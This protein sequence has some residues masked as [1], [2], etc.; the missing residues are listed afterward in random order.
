MRR[1][2][3]AL[4]LSTAAIALL[5]SCGASVPAPIASIA[6]MP[7][8]VNAGTFVQLDASASRDPQSRRLTF[9][10][11]FTARPLGSSAT[12]IDANTATPSFLADLPGE[13]ALNLT[14]SNSV[15]TSTAAATVTVQVSGCAAN[16][17]A[18][19]G[20]QSS[21]TTV[22]IGDSAQFSANVE[23][24]DNLAPCNLDQRLDYAWLLA[25]Q[26]EGSRAS[27]NSERSETPSLTADKAGAYVL[28]LIVT[29]STGRR[30]D[31]GKF[32][33][34]VAECG[35]AT[36]VVA[37]TATPRTTHPN[38]AV[39]LDADVMDADEDCGAEQTFTVQWSVH[40]KPD[41]STPVLSNSR[42]ESPTFTADKAGAYELGVVAT[43]STG[44]S[45]DVGVV[46]VIVD[47]CGDVAPTVASIAA[48]SGAVGTP[49]TGTV[50]TGITVQA[51]G[52][53]SLNCLA[54]GTPA[55]EWSL[56]VPS[57]SRAALSNPAA[58]SPS[59]TPDVAGDYQVSVQVRDSLGIRSAPAVLRI[60]VVDCTP[61]PIQFGTPAISAVATDPD[62][63]APTFSENGNPKPHVGAVVQLTPHAS[64]ASYCGSIAVTPLS[65]RWAITSRPAGSQGALDSPAAASPSLRIDRN[66][67][68][69][70]SVIAT[71]ARGNESAPRSVEIDT[72][73]CGV[74]PISTT[75]LTE[76][77]GP[78]V[79]TPQSPASV[80]SFA[81]FTIAAKIST[82]DNVPTSCPSRFQVGADFSYSVEIQPAANTA[83]LSNVFGDSTVFEASQTGAYAVHVDGA[84]TNL[85]GRVHAPPEFVY[86]S[87]AACS[88]PVLSGATFTVNGAFA[89]AFKGD[90]IDLAVDATPGNCG[91]VS[92][93]LTYSW[94]LSSPPGSA[95]SL[96]A[97]SS[98][99]PSFTADVAGASFAAHVTATDGQGNTSEVATVII[100]V[101]SCGSSP[102]LANILDT[103]GARPFDDHLLQAVPAS[104][105]SFSADEASGCP[106]RFVDYSFAWSVVS[107][108]PSTGFVF[109]ETTSSSVKFTP[110][111]NAVYSIKLV[112]STS[113]Q[114][115][116]VLKQVA[117][118]CSDVVPKTGAVTVASSTPGYPVGSIFRDDIARL[119]ANPTSLCFSPGSTAY[120][121]LWSFTAPTGS[122]SQLNSTTAT[123][124]TFL[125]DL[126]FA[127]YSVTVTVVDK[128][129]NRSPET[130]FSVTSERCGANPILASISDISAGKAFDPHALSVVA[131]GPN[132]K[133]SRDDES[134]LCPARF[135]Q[136]YTFA[137]SIASYG[138]Q[139]QPTDFI[140]N[141]PALATPTEPKTA[142]FTAGTNGSYDVSVL[143][144]GSKFG[145]ATPH[146]VIVVNCIAPNPVVDVPTVTAVSDPENYLKAGLYFRDDTISF[147]GSASSTACYSSGNFHPTFEW[148]LDSDD[149]A[150][151]FTSSTTGAT[152]AAN[153]S[154][155]S[156]DVKLKV[157]DQWNHFSTN[158]FSLVT[159][160]CGKNS[161][162]VLVSAVQ[163][164]G[165][166]LAFDPYTVAI[167][168]SSIDDD[169]AFCPSRFAQTYML[170]STVT[171]PVG[172]THFTP[173]SSSATSFT[174]NIGDN[175]TF[176]VASTATGN[177]SSVVGTGSVDVTVNCPDPTPIFT[178]EPSTAAIAAQITP[179]QADAYYTMHPTD[180][181]KD[182]NVKLTAPVSFACYSTAANAG[183]H[184]NWRLANVD[185]G[186]RGLP[187]LNNAN[188][189]MPDFTAD[190]SSRIYVIGVK[191]LD[192]WDHQATRT[193]RFT[194]GICGAAPIGV[195]VSAAQTPPA[196]P[197]DPWTLTAVPATSS[198]FSNDSDPSMCPVRFAPTYA[199]AWSLNPFSP[200]VQPGTFS[201]PTTNPTTFTPAEPRAY[202]VHLAVTGNGQTGLADATVDATCASPIAGDPGVTEVN[203]A[204]PGP[205]IYVGDV[206]LV[207]AGVA[208]QCFAAPA[209]SSLHYSWT[210]LLEGGTAPE[211]FSPNANVPGP[212]FTPQAFGGNY[213][214]TVAISD[215]SGQVG[216]SNAL[217]IAVS[218]CGAEEP[219]ISLV[220]ARQ[221]FDALN[222]QR[223]SETL[224]SV[225][226]LDTE[227]VPPKTE[228]QATF[229]GMEFPVPF[230][231][232]SSPVQVRVRV[233]SSAGGACP[234]FDFLGA[235][236]TDPDGTEVAT[237]DFTSP[238]AGSIASGGTLEFS[239]TPQVGDR[240]GPP[241]VAGDYH[242]R[243][244]VGYGRPQ[245][246]FQA[247]LGPTLHVAG[248]CGRNAPFPDFTF[249]PSSAAALT[250]VTA[251][252]SL[253]SDEDKDPL[254]LGEGPP[255]F[256]TGC[257]LN[258]PLAYHWDLEAPEDSTT[259]LSPANGV[260]TEFTPDLAGPYDVH[261]TVSDGTTSG[262]NGDG[263]AATTQ[264]YIATPP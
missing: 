156:Y 262:D 124:P 250:L 121:Y 187:T 37:P 159:E 217:A 41:G 184:Y 66:G 173:A 204:T 46:T 139:A 150:A 9:N 141:A 242:L 233:D 47:A 227:I 230:Y 158:H 31:P 243:L 93:A 161:V 97:A 102:I 211:E 251:D 202:S 182:D 133:F 69:R 4:V 246:P 234:S 167:D 3:A 65:Y 84:V 177:K 78:L 101:S 60:G 67:S 126:P 201:S 189:P 181:F 15:V 77:G 192:R 195:A 172:A 213:T 48:V 30:S 17:P 154:G 218:S 94:S 118:S 157:K 71:D 113:S 131:T 11:S 240:A 209:P 162:N 149:G 53:T 59:F 75:L 263:T 174:L 179:S 49:P 128:L 226:P 222:Q 44:R 186:R 193:Q 32:T 190:Q 39:K 24:A 183:L 256:S 23:D 155:G 58:A 81:P 127:L 95:A 111:G 152:L 82:D 194:S 107:S 260:T 134:T 221:H 257:G 175:G 110:G 52:V 5:A 117:V 45:S 105:S 25:Q 142:D 144:T 18:I 125:V 88:R 153:K 216:V 8:V 29:D 239:F 33:L 168:A 99:T 135:A 245:A 72:T 89:T 70:F 38:A 74:N 138:G 225:R 147:S 185:D 169:F 249:E 123:N 119:S 136:T 35:A 176:H 212:T 259:T 198:F 104:G 13:F 224:P 56:A 137:W 164:S 129:G 51:V 200:A 2:F 7:E 106:A 237:A 27:L 160:L 236:L 151:V 223:P 191:A 114:R 170:S 178:N 20:I 57:G 231:L 210:L 10:W 79:T 235:H 258:Q 171:S 42:A 85:A 197:M 255:N 145:T 40:S 254:V 64:V 73:D 108:A 229:D 264:Q 247:K 112:V 207:S 199:F 80:G 98:A 96:V 28:R 180:F 43:D 248:R 148:S 109:N 253:S 55:T 90:R 22:N 143:I 215:G 220:S 19:N 50:G 261:L 166:T 130:G 91:A 14:V 122:T 132:G 116:E 34:E 68:Y 232:A 115:T 63:S 252:A 83:S 76:A 238:P 196:K 1:T 36:P 86:L 21:R 146:D 103:A 6:P 214:V 205:I 206:V 208:S 120:S 165:E 188:E 228:P 163:T 241:V 244:T 16:P 203:G 26:P 62:A 54:T 219:T 92:L 140:F 61:S 12:L 100:A 87:V